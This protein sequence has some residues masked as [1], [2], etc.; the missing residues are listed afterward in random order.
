MI[1]KKLLGAVLSVE[2]TELEILDNKVK[3]NTH[4]VINASDLAFKCKDWASTEGYNIWS[5][6]YELERFN[7][8]SATIYKDSDYACDEDFIA[9]SEIDTIFMASEWVLA[10][11]SKRNKNG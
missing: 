7:D 10:D 5:G 8:F 4:F 3:Y 11:L 1:S 2:I 6:Y 9:H